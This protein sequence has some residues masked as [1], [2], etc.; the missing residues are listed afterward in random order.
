MPRAWEAPVRVAVGVFTALSMTGEVTVGCRVLVGW[1]DAKPGPWGPGVGLVVFL[2]RKA[3][4]GW[5]EREHHQGGVLGAKLGWKPGMPSSRAGL[6]ERLREYGSDLKAVI[7]LP[8]GGQPA[9][10]T[11]RV[12]DVGKSS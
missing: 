1:A 11:N 8:R 5:S 3:G 9:Q 12:G 7:V 10:N 2:L 4:R 6:N